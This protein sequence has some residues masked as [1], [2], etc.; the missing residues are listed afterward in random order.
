MVIPPF[1]TP[2]WYKMIIFSRENSWVVGETRHFRNPPPH[3]NHKPQG[4]PKQQIWWT[5]A[6]CA[7][8]LRRFQSGFEILVTAR[9]VGTETAG[10]DL[11][12]PRF[13][14]TQ[15]IAR[16]EVGSFLFVDFCFRMFLRD[17]IFVFFP[18]DIQ[19]HPPNKY[20][21]NSPCVWDVYGVWSIWPR[22]RFHSLAFYKSSKTNCGI[23]LRF[24][25]FFVWITSPG[26]K[27]NG[28]W[29]LSVQQK[30]YA[31]LQESVENKDLCYIIS[32]VN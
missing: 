23:D 26:G 4:V 28:R 13:W 6:T 8:A 10:K 5:H 18:G 9:F 27:P 11:T 20:V 7:T 14:W 12:K 17:L 32:D 21:P 24:G 29:D 1:H 31:S 16:K 30:W 15:K 22:I 3:I 19:Y 25:S 2:K